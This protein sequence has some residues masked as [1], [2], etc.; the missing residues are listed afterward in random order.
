ML[1]G[2]IIGATGS[3]SH[4]AVTGAQVRDF[5]MQL[6]RFS[7]NALRCLTYL[8]L[9]PGRS[10]RERD[11]AH[12]M[13]MS[14]TH[15]AKVVHRLAQLGYVEASR[16]RGGGVKLAR[17]PERIVIGQVV[18]ATEENLVL[19]ECFDPE[20]NQC[21]IA[22]S[23][24]LAGALDDALRAFFRVLDHVTLADLLTRRRRLVP[25]LRAQ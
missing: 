5:L 2:T 17:A 11:I 16:G 24:A 12:G 3:P 18:R 13:G 20:S 21:P 6:T 4:R 23:C 14:A 22:P 10:V 9:H 15:L 1:D 8:G 19:V 25:L 7:D